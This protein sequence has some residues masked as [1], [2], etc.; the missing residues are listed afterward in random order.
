MN[1][2]ALEVVVVVAMLEF[3]LSLSLSLYIMS[4][5]KQKW[6]GIKDM[7]VASPSKIV[8]DQTMQTTDYKCNK[9]E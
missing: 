8:L 3:F 7:A 6:R 2:Y 1:V 5:M 4:T 9:K